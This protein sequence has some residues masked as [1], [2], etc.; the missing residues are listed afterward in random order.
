MNKKSFA[1]TLSILMVLSLFFVP[2]TAPVSAASAAPIAAS[3]TPTTS[4]TPTPSIAPT[5]SITSAAA[6]IE[7]N[8][9]TTYTG[10][11]EYESGKYC[12]L[13]N[14]VYQGNYNGLYEHSKNGKFYFLKD[15]IWLNDY[16]GLYEHSIN[17]RYYFLKNGIWQKG[18]NGLYE[19]S[20]NKNYYYLNNGIWNREYNGLYEHSINH[21]FYY[22]KSGIWQKGYQG[23]YV[24]S[25]NGKTYYLENG[26]WTRVTKIYEH[27]SNGMFYA[28]INGLWNNTY[29]G[30]LRYE[31]E[32]FSKYIADKI[33]REY[34]NRT[35]YGPFESHYKEYYIRDYYITR[36]ICR[37]I[38]GPVK[39][40]DGK[41]RMVYHGFI[42]ELTGKVSAKYYNR[43]NEWDPNAGTAWIMVGRYEFDQGRKYG[44][45]DPWTDMWDTFKLDKGVIVD[46][47]FTVDG[48]LVHVDINGNQVA[49]NEG[50]YNKIMALREK[51][52]QGTQW[53]KNSSYVWKVKGTQ[54]ELY[55][56]KAFAALV[57]DEVFGVDAP[58][59]ELESFTYDDIKMGD[60]VVVEN[61]KQAVVV[62]KKYVDQLYILEGNYIYYNEYL[63]IRGTRG[64]VNW[65]RYLDR[66]DVEAT[67]VLL[68][69]RYK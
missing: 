10:L 35:T 8:A 45:I 55:G 1:L 13:K 50:V 26:L 14:G 57:S 34:M 39:C 52:P 4:I 44:E 60:I 29:T 43:Q 31:D 25:S 20:I 7:V 15:G 36:G 6:Q 9:P 27:S 23:L 69:T 40:S 64:L 3:I 16:N 32:E 49:F 5:A 59:K 11:Y 67:M 12:Y 28:V 53:D 68:Q 21:R 24:H 33:W 38:W 48:K 47:L 17:H 56:S 54:E 61:G 42:P 63:N 22:L 37:D 65:G 58:L 51:Y 30:I 66:E 2:G 19:H 62:I 46:S 18:Y 41:Y